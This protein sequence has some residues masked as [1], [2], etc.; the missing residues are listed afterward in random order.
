MEIQR[1]SL[2]Q[3]ARATTVGLT[4]VCLAGALAACND[5]SADNS[6]ATTAP[7]PAA[8]SAPVAEAPVTPAPVV[9]AAPEEHHHHHHEHHDEQMSQAGSPPPVPSPSYGP[10]P[11]PPPQICENCGTVQSVN[12]VVDQSNDSGVGAVGGALAG[13]VLGHQMGKGKGKQAMTVLGAI[14][15]ALAGNAV[16][17]DVRKSQHYDVLVRLDNGATQTFKFPTQPGYGVGQHV[18]VEGGQLVAN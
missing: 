11:P 8:V 15:G 13:G 7:A 17:K 10:P 16:E 2:T 12:L 3:L 1:P 4:L 5:K 14:G 6:A 9:A 18:K